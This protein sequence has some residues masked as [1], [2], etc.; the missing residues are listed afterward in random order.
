MEN[1]SGV[2]DSGDA[3]DVD[4]VGVVD[5]GESV[6]DGGCSWVRKTARR[7]WCSGVGVEKCLRGSSR[8]RAR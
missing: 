8:S 5:G 7:R 3:V 4:D 6:V 2:E 1:A